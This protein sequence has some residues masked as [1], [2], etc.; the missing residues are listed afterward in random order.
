MKLGRRIRE[1]IESDY[2]QGA[3]EFLEERPE[4]TDDE[5]AAAAKR[6]VRRRWRH[7]HYGIVGFLMIAALLSTL[8]LNLKEII[9]DLRNP[10][11]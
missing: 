11:D 3:T 8:W 10:D 4:A 7:G 6:H 9:D 1:R 2:M 5:V